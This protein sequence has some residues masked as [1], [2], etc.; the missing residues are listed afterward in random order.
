M[1]IGKIEKIFVFLL[2]KGSV[3]MLLKSIK[4]SIISTVIA[5][6]FLSA[7]HAEEPKQKTEPI[8]DTQT[9]EVAAFLDKLPPQLLQSV[10]NSL[11][12]YKAAP[13]IKKEIAPKRMAFG[14]KESPV[15]IIKWLDILCPHCKH[16]DET[17]HAIL[18]DTPDDSWSLEIRNYPLDKECNSN[19]NFSAEDGVRCLAA[20]VMICQTGSAELERIRFELFQQQKFL[21]TERIWQSATSDEA[22]KKKL[23]AC[24]KSA[25]TAATLKEDIDF[26]KQH[27]ITGTPLLAF[28]NKRIEN[29]PPL[30]YALILAK[31]DINNPAFLVLP[32]ATPKK[33]GDHHDHDHKHDH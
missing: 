19:V 6:V 22:Q 2:T 33:E 13:E 28:N 23:E 20:K 14:Q 7:A 15:H 31:G 12:E 1:K 4:T 11:A 21:T 16:M 26:A 5:S 24:V 18:Q 3:N 8:T 10:S 30:I 25:E 9:S 27:G 29:F 32:P 17:L